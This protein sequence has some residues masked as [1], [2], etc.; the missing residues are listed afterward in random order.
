MES[1]QDWEV[2]MRN[3]MKEFYSPTK[4]Q[5]LRNKIDTFVQLPMETIAEALERFN[6]EKDKHGGAK[7]LFC[8]N[9]M[10]AREHGGDSKQNHQV[11]RAITEGVEKN[12]W[13]QPREARGH[14][15]TKQA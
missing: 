10:E 15:A 4:T 6:C 3:F 9:I 11:V 8:R 1:K 5:S 7:A 14:E 13:M 2:L 12:V